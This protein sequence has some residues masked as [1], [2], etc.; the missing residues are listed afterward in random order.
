MN[1]LKNTSNKDAIILLNQIICLGEKHNISIDKSN[2][3]QELEEGTLVISLNN[4]NKTLHIY[5]K[6]N[7]DL[8]ISIPNITASDLK[9]VRPK[10]LLRYSV[11]IIKCK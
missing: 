6:Q 11:G 3:C 9:S 1:L 5:S 2:L 8:S 4:I 10:A 7:S